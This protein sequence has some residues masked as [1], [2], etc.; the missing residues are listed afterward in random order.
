MESGRFIL[1]IALM[2][3][4]V[5]LVNVVFLPPRA[6]ARTPSPAPRD[7]ATTPRRNAPSATTPTS[8]GPTPPVQLEAPIQAGPAV[9]VR[10][11]TIFVETPLYRFGFSTRG[12][13][14][15]SAE[16]LNFKSFT[17]E[18]PVQLVPERGPG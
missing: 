18:G 2:I 14:L 9:A 8:L 10:T 4:V 16:L 13:G 12:A 6:A 5:V 11:D 3:A 7:S 15:V 17:R 1:A